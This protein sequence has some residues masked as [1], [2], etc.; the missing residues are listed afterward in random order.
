M[1]WNTEVGWK[2]KMSSL[3]AALGL[4]QL[5]RIEDLVAYK[6]QVFRWYESLLANV[7]GVSLN[8]EPAAIRQSYWMVTVVLDPQLGLTKEQVIEHLRR[9]GIDSRPFFYPLSSLP[10]FAGSHQAERARERNRVSYAISP[11]GV[12]LPS[13]MDMTEDKVRYVC[14]ALREI[15]DAHTA[16]A[17]STMTP[18]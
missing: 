9:V 16:R 10:A 18:G 5:E 11:Y 6:R 2:Y 4:A 8:R 17:A 3:Q 1:F 12:N 13:G 14:T 15:L 7:V